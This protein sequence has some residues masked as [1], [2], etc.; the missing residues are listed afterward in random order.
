VFGPSAKE[1]G[2]PSD[3]WRYYLLASRPES[4][5]STFSWND[6]VRTALLPVLMTIVTQY[7]FQIA[8]NNNVLL[9]K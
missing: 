5:D 4:A 6:F 9:N 7:S 3:V 1:T 2:V 8:A